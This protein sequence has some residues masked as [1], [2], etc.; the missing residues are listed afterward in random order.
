M[1]HIETT[2]HV[3]HLMCHVS[4]VACH[5]STMPSRKS[6]GKANLLIM[7]TTPNHESCAPSHMLGFTCHLSSVTSQVS[8]VT[9]FSPFFYKVVELVSGGC[10]VTICYRWG[11]PSL[12]FWVFL[13]KTGWYPKF[14]Y[15]GSDFL[16]SFLTAA[17]LNYDVSL[18]RP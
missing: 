10:V 3:S 1:M 4:G 2:S 17:K 7:F 9:I 18:I 12:F 13:L 14:T 11:L 15:L 5:F 6:Y 16:T 8:H